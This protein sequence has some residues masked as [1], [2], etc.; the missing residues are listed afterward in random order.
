MAVLHH[1]VSL[2]EAVRLLRGRRR[3]ADE[4]RV[5][6]FDDLPPERVDGAVRLVDEDEL[7]RFDGKVSVVDDGERV[8][9]QRVEPGERPARVAARLFV[10]RRRQL[11]VALEHGVQALHRADHDARHRVELVRRQELHVVELREQPPVVGC[12]VALELLERLP[13][14]VR[15]VDEEEHA[16]GVGE[17][18]QTV[19]ARDRRVRLARARGHLHE[20][21][22]TVSGERRLELSHGRELRGPERARVDAGHGRQPRAERGRAQR[23]RVRLPVDLRKPERI[24]GQPLGDRLRAVKR[25]HVPRLGGRV[26]AIREPRLDAGRLVQERQRPHWSRDVC[27]EPGSVLLGLQLYAGERGPRSLRLDH[28]DGLPVDVEQVVGEPVRAERELA[29]GDA[30]SGGEVE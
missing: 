20:R 11:G 22:R 21:A 2:K 26:E 7:E 12:A 18:D 19:D 10:Q 17:L 5:P 8:L 14:E 25:E 27:G 29:D 23:E 3:E 4:E 16:V 15:A 6:V 13:P 9:A 24:F 28:A 1:E 30:A